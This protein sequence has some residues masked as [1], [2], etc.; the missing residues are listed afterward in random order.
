MKNEHKRIYQMCIYLKHKAKKFYKSIS[1]NGKKENIN[2]QQ[3]PVVRIETADNIK[4]TDA[5]HEYIFN[6]VADVIVSEEK[7]LTVKRENISKANAI[8]TYLDIYPST[9][10]FILKKLENINIFLAFF[11]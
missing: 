9:M 6:T 10:F 11:N 7:T 2:A 4:L 8:Y 3:E 5:F 1:V